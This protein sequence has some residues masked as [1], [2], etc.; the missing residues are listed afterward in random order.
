MTANPSITVR[1]G[2][3]W[4][5]R[6]GSVVSQD[7]TVSLNRKPKTAK[8]TP[9]SALSKLNVRELVIYLQDEI[10]ALL[11]DYQWESNTPYLRD[12]IKAKAD[13]IC[14]KVKNNGGIQE[15]L[16]VC[17]E[18]NNTDDVIDNEM[19]VLSTS[20]EPGRACGKMVQELTIYRSGQLKALIK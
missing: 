8:Q 19:F 15:Y 7:V 9:V 14:E 1:Y 17:D 4:G 3:N 2:F 11:Q 10:E 6:C 20:I 13:T 16:N 12:L 5:A 18:S